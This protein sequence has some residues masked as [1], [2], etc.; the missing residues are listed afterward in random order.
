M[1][2]YG[3]ND[4][5]RDEN[6]HSRREEGAP[7]HHGHHPA[8]VGETGP[9]LSQDQWLAWIHELVW[10]HRVTPLW[11]RRDAVALHQPLVKGVTIDY[12]DKSLGIPSTRLMFPSRS[13]C[14]P[15]GR[16]PRPNL[17]TCADTES[18]WMF[19]MDSGSPPAP[20]TV[21]GRL[22]VWASTFVGAGN[23]AIGELILECAA[24]LV[25]RRLG[26]SAQLAFLQAA[27][28]IRTWARYADR[29]IKS[30][31][32][33]NPLGPLAGRRLPE[34]G[35][36]HPAAS[37]DE[38]AG[39]GGWQLQ[40]PPGSCEDGDVPVLTYLEM[41]RPSELLPA[42]SPLVDRVQLTPIEGDVVRVLTLAVGCKFAWP[43]HRWDR[44][45]WMDY[46]ANNAMRHWAGAVDGESIGLVSLNMQGHPD[47][48]IDSFGVLPELI[49]R[50]FGGAFLTE[51][52]A[53]IWALPAQR[54]WL[55]TSSDDHPNALKNYLARGF[56]R[57]QPSQVCTAD[58]S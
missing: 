24:V 2:A 40:R 14:S 43:S 38:G 52:V 6:V 20:D 21:T 53:R 12:I 29:R 9:P 8:P 35:C 18:H 42:T 37:A 55:H 47:V 17:H 50:G 39:S 56:R 7:R 58:Q 27:K 30:P 11:R 3:T 45:Q 33:A 31:C 54:I 26:Y 19:R 48:E 22:R 23:R 57:F 41:T 15:R 10:C 46:L 16:S 25:G 4:A 51:A 1:A 49:G 5:Q 32:S 13:R 28:G 34:A 44:Q 36:I